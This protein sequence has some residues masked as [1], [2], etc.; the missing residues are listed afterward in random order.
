MTLMISHKNANLLLKLRNITFY[1]TYVGFPSSAG[2]ES[3]CNT[4]DL[5]LIPVWEDALE[6]GMTT[7]SSILSWRIPWTL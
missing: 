4:G 5:G 6:K 1:N 2:K 3:A 7:H